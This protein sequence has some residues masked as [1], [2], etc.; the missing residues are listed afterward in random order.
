VPINIILILSVLFSSELLELLFGEHALDLGFEDYAVKVIE[1]VTHSLSQELVALKLTLVA[2][3]V[4]ELRLDMSG[5]LYAA[6]LSGAAQTALLDLLLAISLDYNGIDELYRAIA[7]IY[8]A[9][10]THN[11]HLRSGESDSAR[12]GEGLDE[13]VEQIP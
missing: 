12:I 8:D 1:L 3:S 5:A 6:E 4:I 10:A 11:A 7:Y 9:N 13:I 2:V